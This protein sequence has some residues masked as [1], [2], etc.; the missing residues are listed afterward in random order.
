MCGL[1]RALG[2]T[3]NVVSE[4]HP[5][6]VCGLK[7]CRDVYYVVRL[8]SHPSWV[9]GLKLLMVMLLDMLNSHT[10]RGCVD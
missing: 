4:S 6:W 9:C 7:P 3:A 8:A 2:I 1:K 10:L 5:S